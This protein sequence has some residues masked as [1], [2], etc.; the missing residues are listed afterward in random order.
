MPFPLRDSWDVLG[1]LK[2]ELARRCGLSS[3]VIVTMGIHDSNASLLPHLAKRKG[4]DFILNSTGYVVR[5]HASARRATASP[6][7]SSARS[8]SSIDPLITNRSR[9]PYSSAEWSSRPGLPPSA[10]AGG[11]ARAE[12]RAEVYRSVGRTRRGV[13]PAGARARLGAV[14]RIGSEG[15]RGGP[16]LP[17][18][19]Y[20]TAAASRPS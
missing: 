8:S 10:S 7:T 2:P 5:P 6:P 14:P 20:R 18:R 13:H 17:A 1:K 11:S 4:R 12:P 3:E 15:S 16:R 19:R 9:L